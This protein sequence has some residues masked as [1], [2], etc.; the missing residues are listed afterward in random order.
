LYDCCHRRV[1]NSIG[2]H[3]LSCTDMAPCWTTG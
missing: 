1:F 3:Y 2:E